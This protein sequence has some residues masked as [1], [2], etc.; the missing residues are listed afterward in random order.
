MTLSRSFHRCVVWIVDHPLRAYLFVIAMTA[1]AALGYFDPHRLTD[2]FASPPEVTSPST[3]SR[4]ANPVQP[5]DVETVSLSRAD[6]VLVVESDD[7]FTQSGARALR[8]VVDSLEELPYVKNVLWLDR[9]P[10]LNIFGLPQPLLPTVEASPERFAAAR[11]KALAH[12]LIGGQL[13]S[14]DGRTLLMLVNFDWLYVQNDDDCMGRLRRTAESAAARFPDCK[15]RFLVTGHVPIHLTVLDTHERNQTK[16]QLIGYGVV[17]VMAMILF[18][19]IRAVA[20]V[21]FAV[22]LGVF[23]ALGFLRFF[24]LQRNPFNDVVLPVMLSLVGLT[25]GVHVMLQIRSNRAAGMPEREAARTGLAQVGLACLLTALTTAIGFGSLG[26]AHHETVRTFGWSCVLGVILMFLAVIFTIPLA[27]STWLG[28][29]IH[30]GHEKG[31]ID[32][33]LI[34][35]SGVVDYMIAHAKPVSWLGIG[36]T[37]TMFLISLLLRPDERRSSYLPAEAEATQALHHLD[38]ALGGL[39]F[40]SVEVHWT[41]AV[42]SDSPEVLSVIA[43]VD[44]L[45]RAEPLLG[46]S[47]S[48]RNLIDALPGE[49]PPEERMSLLE[50]L[51]PPLKRAFYTPE[52]RTATV[53]FRVRDLGIAK[54]GPVFERVEAG[55]TKIASEHPAFSAQLAGSAVWRWRNLYQIV[56]DLASSLGSESIIIL[57]VLGIVYRSPRIGLIAIVPNLFPLAL[58]G[59][60]LVVTGQSL[61]IVSVCAFTICL[62]IAVDDT[63]HYLTRFE[64]EREETDNDADAIRRAFTGVGTGM[65]MTT[66]VLVVGFST[67]MFSDMRDQRVFAAMGTLTISTALIGDLVFLPALLAYFARRKT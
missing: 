30:I 27:C 49:G 60:Y 9:V 33:H 31:L 28:R 19:G 14:Q 32:R 43:Q 26:F 5:P 4:P 20:I 41:E 21:T 59:T 38:E 37:L 1:V 50:L 42:E 47:L 2:L 67:V 56:I 25:D 53:T 22:S 36:L 7:I 58:T 45:L 18:R 39:E 51:P 35:V 6:A 12:P 46:R 52:H 23:W 3:S 8:E 63:I 34:H 57:V 40:S 16:Y 29:R 55:L 61:E 24:D 54:Y 11:E 44:D 65:I 48:I 62:G 15:L 17:I 13:L 64:E 66:L 10:P